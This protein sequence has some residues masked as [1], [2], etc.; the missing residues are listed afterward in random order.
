M[1]FDNL[2]IILSAIMLLLITASVVLFIKY[3]QKNKFANKRIKKIEDKFSKDKVYLDKEIKRLGY[4]LDD[5]KQKG[6]KKREGS[7]KQCSGI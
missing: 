4:I 3:K 5:Y 6:G 1:P 2:H 7:S